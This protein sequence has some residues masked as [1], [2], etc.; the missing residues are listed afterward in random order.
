MI[1]VSLEMERFRKASVHIWNSYLMPGLYVVR[2]DIEDSFEIIERELLRC[3]VLGGQS[4]A[5]D[6][7]RKKPIDCLLVELADG[8]TEVPAYIGKR[9]ENGNMIWDNAI[10]RTFDDSFHLQ[11]YDFFDWN[12]FGHIEYE[13]VRVVDST[14]N[15]L[16]LLPAESC[17]F[18]LRK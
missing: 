2:L 15:Q 10:L 13:F 17:S 18:W 14:T 6:N 7:Y 3:L 5:A 1:E 16:M 4:D 8:L 12:H 9:D 11:F